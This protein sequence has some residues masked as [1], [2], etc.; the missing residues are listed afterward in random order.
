MTRFA[1]LLVLS[2]AGAMAAGCGGFTAQS[3]LPRPSLQNA[4][5]SVRGALLYVAHV[6]GLA[7]H[8]PHGVVAIL[9]YPQGNPV[10]T[11]TGISPW[12]ICSDTAGN[13][14]VVSYTAR[15]WYVYE[16]AH[17]GT[18][19]IARIS[20]PKH[21]SF[22][23]SC[24]VDP[25]SGD[26][27][28]ANQSNGVSYTG[29]IDVWAGAKPG[30][31]VVYTVPFVPQNAAYDDRGNLF[32]DGFPGGSDLNLVFGELA[33]GS[34]AVTRVQLDKRIGLPGGVQW[35]GKYVAVETGGWGL[36]NRL[37]RIYR[38]Q[39]SG[40]IGKVVDGVY[41]KDPKLHYA[42]YICIDGKSVVSMAGS[43]GDM[44]YRWPY[45]AGGSHTQFIGHFGSIRG[46]TISR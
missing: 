34:K 37:S 40:S 20:M 23:T 4:A 12:G 18:K 5:P 26:L 29:S 19:P 31:L 17:G 6:E 3:T 10:A 8:Q 28:V 7:K 24:A 11:I 1:R 15:G 43:A 36:I 44:V 46:M 14:W 9:T 38:V 39:V 33:H 25:T 2:V 22:G 27:A 21:Y 35:D 42:T 41:P 32:F 13:V 45:P 16:F 30:K